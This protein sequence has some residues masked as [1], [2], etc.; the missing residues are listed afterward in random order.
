MNVISR[1]PLTMIHAL[2]DAWLEFPGILASFGPGDFSL[3]LGIYLI[4]TAR[5]AF[6]YARPISA[7]IISARLSI[8]LNHQ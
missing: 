2:R 5:F 7:W 4:D 1:Q 8:I 6:V 3:S